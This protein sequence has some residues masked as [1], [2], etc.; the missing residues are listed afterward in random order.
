MYKGFNLKDIINVKAKT[1]S[2]VSL[3]EKIKQ[4]E[5]RVRSMQTN[6]KKGKKFDADNLD[7]KALFG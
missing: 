5:E 6:D 1:E 2:A 3:K 4:N 7:L